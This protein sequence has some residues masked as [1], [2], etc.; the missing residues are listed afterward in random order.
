MPKRR[1]TNRLSQCTPQWLALL[2]E[3]R[4]LTPKEAHEA[5]LRAVEQ[6]AEDEG[7]TKPDH[8]PTRRRRRKP[9]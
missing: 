7:S 4:L 6:H 1:P 2:I 5:H 8:P 9:D 3:M